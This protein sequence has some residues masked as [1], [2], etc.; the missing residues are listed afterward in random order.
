[1]SWGH[2]S[3]LRLCCTATLLSGLNA[4]ADD[5]S[6]EQQLKAT[7]IR[8]FA[9]YTAWP[10]QNTSAP[11]IICLAGQGA[12]AIAGQLESTFIGPR[13]LQPRMLTRPEEADACNALYIGINARLQTTLLARLRDQAVLTIGDS[14]TFLADGGIIHLMSATDSLRFEI[15][16][17]AA[18]RSGVSLNPRLLALAERVLGSGK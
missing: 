5:A 11:L 18:R 17:D 1:M 8:N 2:G 16:L 9:R 12:S 6:P 15:N 10:G 7:F 4:Y 13:S 3:L 14:A